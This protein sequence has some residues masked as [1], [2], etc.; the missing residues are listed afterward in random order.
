MSSPDP[1]AT[2]LQTLSQ[3]L[4]EIEPASVR[5]IADAVENA[6]RENRTIFI[7]GNGG[8]AN[9]ALHLATDL[10]KTTLGT[11][12]AHEHQIRAIALTGNVGLITAWSNDVSFDYVFAEQIR[13]LGQSGD[14]LILLST[15]GASPNLLT[16][17]RVA[18]QM[19]VQS[20][21]LAP[22]TSELTAIADVPVPINAETPQI[23]E[24]LHLAIAHAITIH[25]RRILTRN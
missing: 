16:A 17:A 11:A 25:M 22:A 15:S 3:H 6:W 13:N 20:L 5:P 4:S 12:A 23:A 8:S 18:K 14:L 19:G 9:T 21:A 10:C 24:D 1:F 7:A 2:H